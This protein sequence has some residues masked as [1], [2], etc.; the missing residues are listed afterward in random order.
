MAIDRRPWMNAYDSEE[1][2]NELFG[3]PMWSNTPPLGVGWLG[4][5]GPM[6]MT[7][8]T[9]NAGLTGFNPPQLPLTGPMGT[10]LLGVA[11]ITNVSI[12][13]PYTFGSPSASL[14]QQTALGA[15]FSSGLATAPSA[16]GMPPSVPAFAGPEF[17]AAYG[18]PALLTVVAA[19][20]GQ[21]MG[22]TNDQECEDIIYDALE[23]LPGS[24]E[25][26]V[27]CESSRVTLTGSVP[28]KRLKRDLGEIAWAI[29]AITDV[30]NNITIATKRRSRGASREG[31]SHSTAAR[32]Q[33]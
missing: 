9:A 31:E 33:S 7:G 24:N 8:R 2:M 29:P 1:P 10:N 4:V 14:Q 23:W 11:P 28:H 32:K 20:R 16:F 21:P 18:I 19:R 26:E 13:D 6:S 25:V 15:G 3:A 12:P 5:S 22:P 30:Q 17:V 27:R